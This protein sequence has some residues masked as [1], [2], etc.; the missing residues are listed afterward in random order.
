MRSLFFL[1]LTIGSAS[2]AQTTSALP[3]REKKA[4]EKLPKSLFLIK[5][6]RLKADVS[7]PQAYPAEENLRTIIND[8]TL[9][10]YKKFE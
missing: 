5:R 1:I 4:L 6:A 7:G 9:H 3:E 2:S 8:S 10:S